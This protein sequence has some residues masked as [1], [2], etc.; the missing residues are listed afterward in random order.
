M[1]DAECVR[2]LQWALPRLGL[3][4]AGFRKVRRQVCK[5]VRRRWRS[6][7][8]EG[9]A[10]YR[11]LLER[12]A[13]EWVRL[14]PL[15]R[16]TIS[17]FYRDRG[18]WEGLRDRVLPA[19]TAAATDRLL[20][21]W[22][23]GCG[24]GEEPY[25]LALLLRLEP[26]GRTIPGWSIL[27]TDLDLAQLARARRAVYPESA[28]RDLPQ[29]LR[30]GFQVEADGRLRLRP[31]ARRGVRLVAADLRAPTPRGLFDLIL[32]RNLAFTYFDEARQRATLARLTTALRPGGA[33]VLGTHETLPG[34]ERR[35]APWTDAGSTWRRLQ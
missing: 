35:L 21:I 33:L 11:E 18:V 4:W 19:L 22:S 7:G 26:A 15:C 27:A 14:E 17:R 29:P 34:G 2:F 23:A 13:A 5:R 12:D 24:A 32:C 28:V 1:R 8:L 6:L 25:T 31:S 20:A 10:A 3:R 16:I 30:K 9:F